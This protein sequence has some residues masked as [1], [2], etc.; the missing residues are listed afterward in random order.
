MIAAIIR[1]I[2]VLKGRRELVHAQFDEI[3]TLLHKFTPHSRRT[4]Q[5]RPGWSPRVY[6]VPA[7][8]LAANL[9]DQPARTPQQGDRTAH[10]YR[11]HSP[12]PEALLLLTG[13]VLIEQHDELESAE[14]RYFSEQSMEFLVPQAGEVMLAELNTA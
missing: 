2:F 3:V 6:R 5:Q 9:V 11:R 13:H 10:E 12:S 1:T 8:A 7:C 4:L 14:R